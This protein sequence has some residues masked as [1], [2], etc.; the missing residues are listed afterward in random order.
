MYRVGKITLTAPWK[1]AREACCEWWINRILYFEQ[2]EEG[3]QDIMRAINRP[4]GL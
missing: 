2:A 3:A 4:K 1:L